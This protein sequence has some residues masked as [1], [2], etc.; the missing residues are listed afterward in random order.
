MSESTLAMQL[1]AVLFVASR[2]LM[3]SELSAATGIPVEDVEHELELLLTA[4]SGN[5]IRLSVLDGKFQL[6]TAPQAATAVR[7]FLRDE[8][9]SD[10][11]KPALEALAIVAYRGPL[12]KVEID[13]IRGVASD[14]MIRNLLARG[15]IVE[16]G[17]SSESGRPNLYAISHSFLQH[18]GLTSTSDLP[19]VP[20]E[21]DAN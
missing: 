8:S 16:A 19:E 20:S 2:P 10:L 6:V 14:A 18:F 17:K 11:S 5:G 7:N 4:T 9:A 13:N 21:Q 3:P 15:L 12:T 1:M